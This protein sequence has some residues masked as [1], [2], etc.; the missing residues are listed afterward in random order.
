[1]GTCILVS[2][3]FGAKH[4]KLIVSERPEEGKT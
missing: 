3:V 2:C 4:F 1:M